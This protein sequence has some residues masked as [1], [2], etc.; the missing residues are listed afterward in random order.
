MMGFW[1][2]N[3]LIFYKQDCEKTEYE[4]GGVVLQICLHNVCLRH[5]TYIEFAVKKIQKENSL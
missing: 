1:L 4:N 2:T 3:Y 5:S